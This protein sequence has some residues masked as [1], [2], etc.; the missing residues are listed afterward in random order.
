MP[1]HAASPASSRHLVSQDERGRSRVQTPDIGR[2]QM[3]KAH[4]QKV[5]TPSASHVQKVDM[6]WM[7]MVGRAIERAI[8]MVGWS[9]KEAAAK[10]GV[11]EAE[12][13]KWLSGGRRPQ[14]DRLFAVAELRKP[15]VLCLAALANGR[16]IQRIEFTE[17]E[18][19]L[20]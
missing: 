16:V 13:G 19:V 11:D 18:A 12:F 2:K 7:A 1:V 20:A 10:V 5:D 4:V 8:A 15:L 3:A 6:D 17:A 14:F 9:K